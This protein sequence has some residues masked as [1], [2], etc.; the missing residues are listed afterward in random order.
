V[1]VS[2]C[3]QQLVLGP[4]GAGKERVL[5][6]LPP[7]A[8]EDRGHERRHTDQGERLPCTHPPKPTTRIL[9]TTALSDTTAYVTILRPRPGGQTTPTLLAIPLR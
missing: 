2:R 4:L 9:W 1:R 5:F 8:G 6:T 7:L 3:A